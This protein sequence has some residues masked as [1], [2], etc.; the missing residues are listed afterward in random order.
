[1][2]GVRCVDGADFGEGSA[3]KDVDLAS[4]ITEPGEGD[5]TTLRIEGHEVD[6]RSTEVMQRSDAL[7]EYHRFRGHDCMDTNNV[8]RIVGSGMIEANLHP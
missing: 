1:M 2:R 3:I 4:K 6:R 8:Q 5:E 7:V